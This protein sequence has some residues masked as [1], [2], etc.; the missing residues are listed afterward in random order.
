VSGIPVGE[1]HRSAPQRVGVPAYW[2]PATPSGRALFQQLALTVPPTGIVVVN[3]SRSAPQVPYDPAWADAFRGLGATRTLPLGYVDTGYLGV[4]FGPGSAATRPDGPGGGRRTVAAWTAQ[5]EQ[6][7]DAW[8]SLYGPD[9]LRGIFLDRTTAVCGPDNSYVDSYRQIVDHI[10]RGH[11]GAYVAMN[12]GRSIEACYR[13][14]A[15]TF[16]TFEGS[17]RDYLTR[18]GAP[19][20]A[21]AP[22]G[23]F[24]HL[25][26]GAADPASMARA[27]ELSKRRNAGYVYVT[28]RPLPPDGH[29]HPWDAIPPDSYWQ[30]ELAAVLGPHRHTPGRT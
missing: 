23:T 24:W 6:D 17:Y 28:D 10:R 3:G 1:W 25:V 11:P 30:A 26:Y 5:I 27:I 16:V 19:W 7:A 22:P 9:G 14:V 15:D 4:D 12:P 21:T 13:A 18:A 20:E 2:S 29:A 8:Y